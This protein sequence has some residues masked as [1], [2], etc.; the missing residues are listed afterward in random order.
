V[1][2]PPHFG[3]ASSTNCCPFYYIKKLYLASK[4]KNYHIIYNKDSSGV[5]VAKINI[6]VSK[7]VQ[8]TI[9]SR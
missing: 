6:N 1:P 2:E 3:L 8:L 5:R 9:K 4:N 7:K